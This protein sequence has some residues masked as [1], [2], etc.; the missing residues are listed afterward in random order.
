MVAISKVGNFRTRLS[1]SEILS[2]LIRCKLVR[3]PLFLFGK[4]KEKHMLQKWQMRITG[5]EV[6]FPLKVKR[7]SDFC[8]EIR[9]AFPFRC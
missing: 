8:S 5:I 4:A 3:Y 1:L 7:P 6:D 9:Y 2:D